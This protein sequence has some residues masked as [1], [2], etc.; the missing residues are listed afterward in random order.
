MNKFDIVITDD[1]KD[2]IRNIVNYTESHN[3]FAALNLIKIFKKTFVLL[4]GFPAVGRTSVFIED[5][6]I[7]IYVVKKRFIIAYRF[8]NNQVA[9]LRVLSSYQDIST[10]L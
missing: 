7:L 9:V 5:K 1:A 6:T 4:S 8:Y 10:S 2:D 3:K